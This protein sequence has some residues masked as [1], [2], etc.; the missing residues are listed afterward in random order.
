MR[1]SA[2]IHYNTSCSVAISA[3]KDMPM[4]QLFII[5]SITILCARAFS[6][7]VLC[8]R[9]FHGSMEQE[10]I[11]SVRNDSV[12]QRKDHEEPGP[13]K[14]RRHARICEK[15]AARCRRT[16]DE[17]DAGPK[18]DTT[19]EAHTHTQSEDSSESDKD[20]QEIGDS[21]ENNENKDDEEIGDSD[22]NNEKERSEQDELVVRSDP[23]LVCDSEP[24]EQATAQQS[25]ASP[26]LAP[27]RKES[28]ASSSAA[29]NTLGK[30][31]PPEGP[32]PPH[33]RSKKLSPPRYKP[34]PP[35]TPTRRPPPPLPRPTRTTNR[36]KKTAAKQQPA[37]KQLVK[38]RF[39]YL[40][41]RPVSPEAGPRQRLPR[42]MQRETQDVEYELYKAMQR[43][44]LQRAFAAASVSAAAAVDFATNKQPRVILLPRTSSRR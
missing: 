34:P 44:T 29:K 9:A 30:P 39:Q 38:P 40:R 4:S 26:L 31:K 35:P 10:R 33:L 43:E 27:E 11:V 12:P 25:E 1:F 22:E 28:E 17:L 21:D 41:R 24:E 13:A 42:P 8:A 20:V 36:T 2:A 3:L 18:D 32:P 5:L 16:A 37:A 14:L 7:T 6:I 23:Y 15:M 19:S